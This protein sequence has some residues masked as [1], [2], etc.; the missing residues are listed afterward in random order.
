MK[1]KVLENIDEEQLPPLP[2]EEQKVVDLL[3]GLMVDRYFA[4][5]EKETLI[6]H[7]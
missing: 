2:E 4:T 3:A 6:K 1:D 5:I 7:E